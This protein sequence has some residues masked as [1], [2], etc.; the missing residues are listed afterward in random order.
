MNKDT[1]YG[2]DSRRF[3][4]SVFDLT[5]G[6][7]G[8]PVSRDEIRASL[9]EDGIDPDA[10]W[11]KFSTSLEV[12]RNRQRLAEARAARLAKKD[13]SAAYTTARNNG[14]SEPHQNILQ[15]IIQLLDEM[16]AAG[17]PT[18]G[19]YARNYQETNDEDLRQIYE[20]MKA[21]FERE[22][23]RKHDQR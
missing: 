18:A 6:A 20:S 9:K 15:K 8:E 14:D 21:T 10:A 11:K 17:M 3:L 2:N 12:A 7:E 1:F 23:T 16:K 19:M 13:A 4:K 5:E 22:K